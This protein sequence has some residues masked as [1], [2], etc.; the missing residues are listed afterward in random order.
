MG[1]SHL[2]DPLVL[3]TDAALPIK[4]LFGGK[5]NNVDWLSIIVNFVI[6]FAFIL[7]IAFNLK[8]RYNRKKDLYDE[9]LVV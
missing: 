2:M 9:Y 8:G 3:E 6:P 1:Y 5:L 4:P 7:F